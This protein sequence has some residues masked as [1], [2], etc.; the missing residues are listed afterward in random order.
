[1]PEARGVA[2]YISPKAVKGGESGIEGRGLRAVEPIATGEIVAI[3]GGH[4]VDTATMHRLSPRLQNSEIQIA[5][6]FHLVALHDDEYD[7][8]MLFINHSCAPNVGFAGNVVLVAMRDVAAG[9]ELTTDYALFDDSDEV[10]DCRCG[11][12][13]CRRVIQ[14]RDWQRPELQEKYRGW[15]SRY[16]QDRIPGMDRD[17]PG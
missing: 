4:I 3:K 9:E 14:G 5:D 6:G 17:E 15:F 8:V 7:D 13:E 11:S 16:L 1:V 2:S 10:M 12:P